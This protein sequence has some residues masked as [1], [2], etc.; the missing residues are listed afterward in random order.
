MQ[1]EQ[2]MEADS[3][4]KRW[5]LPRFGMQWTAPP[6]L[7]SITWYGG[8]A[9]VGIY[10]QMTG[11][12]ASTAA[13][14]SSMETGIRWWKITGTNGRGM[15]ITADSSLLHIKTQPR[16]AGDTGTRLTIGYPAAPLPYE[17]PYGNYHYA[18]KVTPV[19]AL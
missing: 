18:Y 5:T 9:A 10:R 2:S 16:S 6:G 11:Q 1:V 3:T 4:Q 14:D 8:D 19:P 17:L 7:D 15:L 13:S 12:Q